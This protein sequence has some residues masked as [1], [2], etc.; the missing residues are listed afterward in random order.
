VKLIAYTMRTGSRAAQQG[1]ARTSVFEVRGSYGES[2]ANEHSGRGRAETE[3]AA[4]L[5][6]GGLRYLLPA[7][8]HTLPFFSS[9]IR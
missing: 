1:V 6:G 9:P 3:K 2:S 7:E 4:D 5:K 8:D